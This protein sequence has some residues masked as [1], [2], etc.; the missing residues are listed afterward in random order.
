MVIRSEPSSRSLSR[1]S[2]SKDARAFLS[3]SSSVRSSFRFLTISS[4]R[5]SRNCHRSISSD[6]ALPPFGQCRL[7]RPNAQVTDFVRDGTMESIQYIVSLFDST[8]NIVSNRLFENSIPEILLY[9]S[10]NFSFAK[11]EQSKNHAPKNSVRLLPNHEHLPNPS[12]S[13][14]ALP[15]PLLISA[16]PV[17]SGID[18]KPGPIHWGGATS[19][20]EPAL[21]KI[22]A[23]MLMRLSD[24][25]WVCNLAGQQE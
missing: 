20:G 8:L 7:S 23:R 21:Q 14:A 12:L 10:N 15:M 17:R 2:F 3:A 1:R 13:P 22:A 11:R 5:A 19:P 4:S 18:G 6:I 25:D 16:P 24:E 9:F